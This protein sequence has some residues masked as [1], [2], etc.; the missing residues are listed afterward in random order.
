M[1]D[2]IE[3]TSKPADTRD[4]FDQLKEVQE[5]GKRAGIEITVGEGG[6]VAKNREDVA[7]EGA[8]GVVR[9]GKEVLKDARLLL[10]EITDDVIIPR[11]RVESGISKTGLLTDKDKQAYYDRIGLKLT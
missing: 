6:T 9:E 5:K 7:I 1:E 11:M 2:L 8:Q 3:K 10:K 4:F